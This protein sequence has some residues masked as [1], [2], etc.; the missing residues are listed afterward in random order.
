[1]HPD[2]MLLEVVDGCELP[3]TLATG[4]G[5][6]LRVHAVLV[7]PEVVPRGEALPAVSAPVG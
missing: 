2:S 6:R 5:L 4:D 7:K 3:R 1:M